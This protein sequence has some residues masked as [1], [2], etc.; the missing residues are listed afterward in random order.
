M[1]MIDVAVARHFALVNQLHTFPA[2]LPWVQG[3]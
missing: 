2:G 3:S 1:F